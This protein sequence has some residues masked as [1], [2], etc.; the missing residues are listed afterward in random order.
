[1]KF[2][3]KNLKIKLCWKVWNLEQNAFWWMKI[4]NL[5]PGPM[6]CPLT[7]EDSWPVPSHM[8]SNFLFFLYS[9]AAYLH[10]KISET[11]PSSLASLWYWLSRLSIGFPKSLRSGGSLRSQQKSRSAKKSSRFKVGWVCW[12]IPIESGLWLE[13]HLEFKNGPFH[14][15]T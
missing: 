6:R 5:F 8:L 13:V 10:L 15:L 9:Q 2:S 4:E 12:L 3:A 14:L 1:M 11:I 7:F